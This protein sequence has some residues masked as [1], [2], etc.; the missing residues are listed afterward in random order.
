MAE[1]SDSEAPMSLP[2]YGAA[3]AVT[4]CGVL[5]VTDSVGDAVFTQEA[6]TLTLLGFVFSIGGRILK[7]NA[8]LVGGL[9]LATIALAVSATLAGRVAWGALVPEVASK[10]DAHVAVILCWCAVLLSWCLLDDST[11]L[12]TPLPAI[13]SLGLVASFDLND[14]VVCYFV[15]L[16]VAT[17]FLL[18]GTQAL[19]LRTLASAGERT[20]RTSG[21]TPTQL[22]LAIICVLTVLVLGFV[23]VTPIEAVTH[24]LS[25]AGAIRK[26][27][28]LGGAISGNPLT[29]R[30]SDD[31]DFSIG[32]G[33]GW[34]ASTQVLMRVTASDGKPHLWQGRTYDHYDGSG[35]QSDISDQIRPMLSPTDNGDGTETFPLAT[36]PPLGR[37]LMSA[38][39]D[40]VGDTD[41]FYYA[42][43]PRRLTLPS[44][45]DIDPRLGVDGQLSLSD[46]RTLGQMH[47]SVTSLLAPDPMD[48]A[49]QGRLRHLGADYPEEIISR[50]LSNMSDGARPELD[51]RARAYFQE[52]VF[53]IVSTLPPSQQTPIDKALAIRDWVS[54]HCTYSLDVA[55]LDDHQDHV[56]QFLAQTRRGYCDL[57][58]SSMAVLCRVAGLPARVVTGF[59]PG[60]P[61]GQ[62]YVLR[63]MDKHAWTEV[64]FPQVGWLSFDPTEGTMTDG[65]VPDPHAK[66]G[67]DW[68]STLK[69]LGALPL[70][71]GVAI[72]AL[73][74]YVAKTEWFDRGFGRA[75]GTDISRASQE[76]VGRRYERLTQLLAGLGLPRWVSE[77]PS[78]YTARAKI[79]WATLGTQAPDFAVL[80]TLTSQLIAARYSGTN[81]ENTESSEKN[82]REFAVQATRLR[83][84]ML[85]RSLTGRFS[86]SKV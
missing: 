61:D 29:S 56:Y 49:I 35:W 71:M 66:P 47:Y 73:L 38:S 79:F 59:A 69:H 3:L 21:Q 83:L 26:L 10:S 2:L 65:S 52:T 63:A 27:S 24:N 13:A 67:W 74:L 51:P 60:V 62:T 20:R 85:W 78:E 14:Y 57:F 36:M 17:L 37:S 34:S 45:L 75:S 28:N 64:Y 7:I 8:R 77:T 42:A 86:R 18:I 46:D 50:Y 48:P 58:A 30:F 84:K 4:L 82:L 68:H 5:T 72:L 1:A 31:S 39:F 54:K 23:L 12:F 44:A 16:L 6:L 33:A 80:D 11:L 9:C 22:T 55:P 53:R 43:T 70:V 41:D 40:I 81:P 19:R 25:L 76:A 32:T 15:L